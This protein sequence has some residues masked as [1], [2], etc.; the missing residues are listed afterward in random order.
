MN[1]SVFKPAGRKFFMAQWVD[2][3][4][5]KKKT[6]STGTAI[7][8]DAERFAAR[9]EAEIERGDLEHERLTWE[10][11]RERYEL[12][13]LSGK[14]QST[15]NEFI[16]SMNIIEQYINPGRPSAITTPVVSSFAMKLRTERGS[17]EMTVRKHLSNLRA[18]MNWAKSQGYVKQVPQFTMPKSTGMKGRPITL[19]EFE[20][21][22]KAI[23]DALP[24]SVS[25]QDAPKY[26]FLLRGLWYSGLRI[27]EALALSW[28][29]CAGVRVDLTGRR[30]MIDFSG[31]H[32]KNGK[33]QLIP[34][35]PDFYE[36]LMT[37]PEAD[38]VGP[39]FG[40]NCT[41]L[42][43][44][45][46]VAAAGKAAGIITKQSGDR[47]VY[48][49][50]H[51]LRRAFGNRWARR[52]PAHDL[53]LLMR[54]SDIQT[55]LKFYVGQ[56]SDDAGDAIW[57]ALA[58]TLANTNE[59]RESAAQQKTPQTF[60]VQGVKDCTRQDSNLKPSVP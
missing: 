37:I 15:K 5:G 21:L 7:Q 53:Q 55:T 47:T 54:H 14:R 35:T 26:Q 24:G 16:T 34:I 22:V 23:P 45:K 17:R 28:D 13:G 4:T 44:S 31:E 49:S 25:E 43:V 41:S 29:A 48:A 19:E 57:N 3:V 1:V 2:Q 36:L 18:I 11:F 32:Q 6:R 56:R 12:V 50:A 10:V 42:H 52:I 33:D 30:P 9:L 46:R 8:R 59:N 38:R 58:N 20:R 40:I 51:D 27:S 39:V 60:A